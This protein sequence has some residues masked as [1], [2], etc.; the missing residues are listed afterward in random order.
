[1]AGD[2]TLKVFLL[3]GSNQILIDQIIPPSNSMNWTSRSISI[4]D[5]LPLG[6]NLQLMVYISDL[7]PNINV[8]EASFD[9]FSITDYNISSNLEINNSE[10][11][12]F[13]NPTNEN[14]TINGLKIGEYLKL[15]DLNGIV[16]KEI[17]CEEQSELFDLVHLSNGIYFIQH[18]GNSY[19]LMKN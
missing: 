10:L 1:M 3:T 19:K 14:V 15:V 8:T 13:P 9:R 7:A 17:V 12:F 2:D 4:S 16:I 11:S 5:L 6:S 18:N